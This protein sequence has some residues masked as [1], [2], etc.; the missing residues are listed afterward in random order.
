MT[1]LSKLRPHHRHYLEYAQTIVRDSGVETVLEIGPGEF[2]IV[3]ESTRLDIDPAAPDCIRHDVRVIPWPVDTVFDLAVCLQCFE[4][5][6]RG[7][8]AAFCEMRRVSRAQLVSIPWQWPSS[9]CEGHTG[10]SW[11]AANEWFGIPPA[12][13]HDVASPEK[14]DYPR[15][16]FYFD[17]K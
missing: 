8:L 6:G 16:F 3:R 13:T 14:P 2:P 5:L 1:D 7:R 4:H 17:Q 9:D 15:R 12:W 11:A 10:L